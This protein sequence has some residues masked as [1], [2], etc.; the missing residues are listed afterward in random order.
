MLCVWLKKTKWV[1]GLWITPLIYYYYIFYMAIFNTIIQ[2][3]KL[4]I[5]ELFNYLD[6]KIQSVIF[7]SLKRAY[8]AHQKRRLYDMKEKMGGPAFSEALRELE[9]K[10]KGDV[11]LFYRRVHWRRDNWIAQARIYSS[12]RDAWELGTLP[13]KQGIYGYC[14][15]SNAVSS[16]YALQS[17]QFFYWSN[18]PYRCFLI[19]PSAA[20]C[21]EEH[22]YHIPESSPWPFMAAL[23]LFTVAL[24]FTGF[25][26]LLL[27]MPFFYSLTQVFIVDKVI[28]CVGWPQLFLFY[29][30][31]N[32]F[33]DIIIEATFEG[34]HTKRVQENLNCG[35]ILFIVSEVMFFFSF[36]WAFFYTSI[37]PP[38]E[39]GWWPPLGIKLFNPFSVPLLNTVILV[40]SGISITWAHNAIVGNHRKDSI[41]GLSITV[42]YGVVF[43]A[44]Q[45]YEYT[46]AL[47]SIND[48]IYGALFYLCTGF[49]GSHVIAGTIF[50]LVTCFRHVRYHLLLTHHAGF[51][52]SAWYWHFVDIVW[53]FLYACIYWYAYYKYLKN[54][55]QWDTI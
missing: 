39:I 41:L 8:N 25:L 33:A 38:I 29:V 20:R 30:F 54:K 19:K 34:H 10:E 1:L 14:D 31:Y 46:S 22:P 52:F 17:H 32:W 4:R 9:L 6:Q 49:H 45:A 2:K 43:T 47:F 23:T 27:P 5:L 13:E 21:T 51:K 3:I 28:N 40:S 53:L 7:K 26:H 42:I 11:L 37:S 36:F 18:P 24:K 50:L 15:W 55:I 12:V 16:F 48:S 44:L 35:M